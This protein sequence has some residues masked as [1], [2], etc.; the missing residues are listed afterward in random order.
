MN[1]LRYFHSIAG[2]YEI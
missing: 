1:K 2:Y